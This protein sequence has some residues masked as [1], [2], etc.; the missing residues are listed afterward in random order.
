MT[1]TPAKNNALAFVGQVPNVRMIKLLGR[2]LP[3]T[4]SPGTLGTLG[5]LGTLYFY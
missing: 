2:T 3:A 1:T 4:T 5:I